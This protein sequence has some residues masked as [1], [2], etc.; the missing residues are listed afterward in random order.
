MCNILLRAIK[1]HIRCAANYAIKVQF[2]N[3]YLINKVERA[4]LRDATH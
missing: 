1:T 3:I 2:I 4:S